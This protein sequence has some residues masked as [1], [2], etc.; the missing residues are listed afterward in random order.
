VQ[1]NSTKLYPTGANTPAPNCSTNPD[2]SANKPLANAAKFVSTAARY[3][4]K[5]AIKKMQP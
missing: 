1:T 3:L 5:K 4:N 2:P